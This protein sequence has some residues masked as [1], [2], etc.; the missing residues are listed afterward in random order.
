MKLSRL[1]E[2]PEYQQATYPQ[3]VCL[4]GR[5][6][7]EW[8]SY[9]TAEVLARAEQVSKGLLALGIGPG[10]TIALI[11]DNRPA[12][13]FLDLGALRIGAVIVP[14]YPTISEGEYAYIFNHA[15]IRLAFVS[16]EALW[17]K[18]NAIRGQVS[19]LREIYTFD[20][21]EGAVHWEEMI[22]GGKEVSSA[23]VQERAD[24]IGTDD[25]AT[26]IY[27]SGTTGTPKGVMLSHRNILSNVQSVT[28]ILPITQEHRVLSFLPLCHIFERMVCYVYLYMGASIYYSESL[29]PPVLRQRM[30]E[31]RPHFF[32]TVPRLLEKIYEAIFSRGYEMRG[33]RRALFFWAL[34]LG[35]RF[36][37]DKKMGSWY[38]FRL[39]IARKLVFSKWRDAL[40][41]EL[42]GIVTGAAALPPKLCKVFSAAGIRVREGY[43]QTESSPVLTLN[44]FE[45]G[46]TLEGSVGIPIPG[47]E[48]RIAENGEICAKGP[49][50]MLGY[51]QNP[52]ATAEAID[53]EGWLHTGDV[54]KI[55]D[56]KFI[57]ITD[58][59]KELFKTSGG[60]YVAPQPIE[61][62]FRES[63]FID[64]MMVVGENQ[65]FVAALI[66][67]AFP[68]LENWCREQGIPYS[69]REVMLSHEKVIARYQEICDDYN[70]AFSHIEQVKRFALIPN[71]WTLDGGE[72]TTSL[73]IK[74]RVIVKKYKAYIDQLY[75]RE[76]P[77]F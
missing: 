69:D 42:I 56:G 35:L 36:Q 49:N 27:T 43:G 66:V 17:G 28:T 67:P 9:S 25:L 32:T 64:Q 16:D 59:I 19:S 24:R 4:A 26:I 54:G 30:T 6:G 48:V 2:I 33:I 46:G 38:D 15:E 68:Y 51:Y 8:K 37:V 55:V 7:D 72:M 11:A 70:T 45:P 57:V 76:M 21:V 23:E 29:D 50:I 20:R 22:A 73:K 39:K 40:G 3:T 47:V 62:R 44:R 13:N 12:W 31:V 52:E 77:L 5:A 10:D 34:D 53:A 65:K 63:F 58:R 71:E 41:G 74:R 18:V 14:V 75:A 60:K 61:N 1:F